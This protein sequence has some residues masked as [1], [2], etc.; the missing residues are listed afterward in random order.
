[1]NFLESISVALSSLWGNKMRSFLT[2]L[3]IIIGISSVI[4]IV[5]LG[6]GSQA[7]IGSEFE[8][9]GANRVALMMNWDEDPRY[10]ER[11]DDE[12]IETIRRVFGDEITG[13][14]ASFSLSGTA[15]KGREDSPLNIY[16]VN[17]DFGKLTN[18]D[19]IEGRFLIE[20]D[21]K[22]SRKVCVIDKKL[23]EKLFKRT[24]VLGEKLTIDT[25]YSKMSM[26]I[27]GVYQTPG[28]TIENLNQQFMG[29]T[30]SFYMPISITKKMGFG[31][32][33]YGLQ[34]GIA[35]SDRIDE[36]SKEIVKVIERKHRNVGKNYYIYYS[37]KQEMDMMNQILGV[38]SKVVG[39]IAGI[40]LVVGGI[41]VMNIMLV[42]VTERTRE[43]GIRK[44]IGATR[45]D[46]LVQ[47]LVEAM[48]ISGTGGLIGT[49]LGLI[50]QSLIAMSIGIPPTVS[51]GTILIAVLFSAAVGIFFG[52]YPANKAAKLDPIDALRYE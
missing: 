42:S 10:E 15:L 24:D 19:V 23:A 45:K 39:A 47:F 44:A 28:G 27:V 2:M 25:G 46:I 32:K 26:T 17:E 3:G 12:D 4:T 7:Q 14:S 48:I 33:Y 18:L 21:I 9:Y 20:S 16:G 41:G 22:G 52:I 30:T 1:M 13:I 31:D 6:Q 37:A 35:D 36:V 8:K 5:A 38:L 49:L 29:E 34:V 51:I 43:I 50:F 40:S 11:Y